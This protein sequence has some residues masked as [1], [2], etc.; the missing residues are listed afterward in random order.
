M[1]TVDVLTRLPNRRRFE[2]ELAVET[3]RSARYGR[4]LSVIMFDL[5][6]FKSVND[7]YGHPAGDEVL[8]ELGALLETMMRT[9]D[10]AY[11]YGG[12]EFVI[13]ARETGTKGAAILAERIR[14]AIEHKFHAWRPGRAVTA[15]L[16]VAGTASGSTAAGLVTA[17]D[18]ALY[19]AKRSGRNRVAIA[20]DIDATALHLPPGEPV[21]SPVP[22]ASEDQRPDPFCDLLADATRDT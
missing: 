4:P 19:T 14:S 15:S 21:Q 8:Q 12:E 6:H 16:G 20:A 13:L 5:D 18:Q 9:S 3:S 17:A 11:R 10:T 22:G 7:T 2:E 1:A